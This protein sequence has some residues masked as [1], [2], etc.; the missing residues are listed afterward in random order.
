[1]IISNQESKGPRRGLEPLITRLFTVK[2]DAL[3]LELTRSINDDFSMAK[4]L[5]QLDRQCKKA[6]QCIP[7]D[8][9]LYLL[10]VFPESF[11]YI[12]HGTIYVIAEIC[13]SGYREDVILSPQT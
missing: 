12:T 1:M 7:M 4:E 10:R 9:G 8:E 13:F 6:Q 11:I 3:P 5:P 2:A